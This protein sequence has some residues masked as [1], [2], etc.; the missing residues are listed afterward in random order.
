MGVGKSSRIACIVVGE[1]DTMK[2]GRDGICVMGRR[3]VCRG[4]RIHAGLAKH[5]SSR[6]S[7]LPL[8]AL[9]LFIYCVSPCFAGA[10]VNGDPFVDELLTNGCVSQSSFWSDVKEQ[11]TNGNID[12]A[13]KR[14]RQ[15][16]ARRE[17]DID[18][19]CMYAMALEMKLRQ[20][21]HDADI[22]DE[23]VRE[24]THVAK[25]KVLADSKGWEHVGDGEVFTQNQERKAMANRHLVSLVGRAPK[26]FESEKAYLGKVIHIRTT[27]AGKVQNLPK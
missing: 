14:C 15:V 5:G 4:R 7:A 10:S 11:L 21:S 27:V 18:M 22:F 2:A 19:H 26:Y 16:M 3:I 13:I 12:E 25:V 8:A 17:L 9:L 6:R 24:W 20:G 1:N 23:C